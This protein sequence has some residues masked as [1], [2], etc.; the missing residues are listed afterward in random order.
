MPTIRRLPFQRTD[1]ANDIAEI[2]KG[3]RLRAGLSR[4]D[5]ADAAGIASKTIARI[6]RG[7][8]KP[9]WETLDRL[10]EV[11]DFSASTVASQWVSDDIDRPVY[12]QSTPGPGFRLLRQS[13]GMTLVGLSKASGVSVST[14]SRFERC[15]VVSSR[16]T[17]RLNQPGIRYEE[18]D[19]VLENDRVAIAL[20][21]PNSAALA[22]ACRGSE[23]ADVSI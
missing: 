21:F 22:L 12:S 16:L 19:L 3:A 15:L 9:T 17:R 14:L 11:M 4:R 7:E 8:Q 18:R 6:E 10:C 13:R 5:A 1:L 2:L 20:G 23:Q